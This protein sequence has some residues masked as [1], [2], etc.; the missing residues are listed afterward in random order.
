MAPHRMPQRRFYRP[1]LAAAL[2]LLIAG[3]AALAPA[4][5]Q[6]A[7]PA[8][9]ATPTRV[10][11]RVPSLAATAAA[12]AATAGVPAS[13]LPARVTRIVDGDTIGVELGGATYRVRYIGMDTPERDTPCFDA[14]TDLNAELVE[15]TTVWLEQDVSE[16]DRYGRLLRHIW[17][18]DGVLVN[19]ELVRQ[20]MAV[21]YTWPPDVKYEARLLAAQRAARAEG[22]GCLWSE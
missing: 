4:P 15:G 3:C 12:P 13:A 22:A 21:V 1:L 8:P 2:P 6:V 5:V 16:V 14:A 18:G 19:E 20:G 9:V 17:T 7:T 11:T 10:A